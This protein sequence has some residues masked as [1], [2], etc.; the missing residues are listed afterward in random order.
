MAT[1][2]DTYIF[3]EKL[4]SGSIVKHL[5]KIEACLKNELGA[6]RIF[7]KNASQR[8]ATACIKKDGDW[9]FYNLSG[10]VGKFIKEGENEW[11]SL[12][13]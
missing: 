8:K 13:W 7:N 6:L 9:E 1:K 12:I 11:K 2:K 3:F 10:I 4:D 5:F